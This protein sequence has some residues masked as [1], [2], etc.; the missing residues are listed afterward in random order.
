MVNLAHLIPVFPFAA[1]VVNILFGRRV[2]KFSAIVSISASTIS[3]CLSIY[4]LVCFLK[5]QGSYTL[6]KWLIF[7]GTSL[8][9]GVIVDPLT[10]MMLVVEQLLERL[11]R[12]TR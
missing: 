8:N 11:Y 3:L 6:F 1:F 7:G 4:T 10:C 5:G 9:I 12:Y 2:K